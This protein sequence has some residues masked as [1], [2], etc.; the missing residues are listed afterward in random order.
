MWHG[1]TGSAGGYGI[2]S[3]AVVLSRQPFD[4][5]LNGEACRNYIQLVITGLKAGC[6]V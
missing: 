2:C 1:D 4:L 3:Q 5:P 6:T